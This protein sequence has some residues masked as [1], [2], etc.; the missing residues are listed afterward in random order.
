MK[1]KVKALLTCLLMVFSVGCDRGNKDS[2]IGSNIGSGSFEIWAAPFT[3]K[4]LE[5][6]E[7]SEYEAVKSVAAINL[8]MAKDEKEYAQIV[9]SSNDEVTYSV[10]LSDLTLEGDSSIK[11]PADKVSVYTAMYVGVGDRYPDAMLPLSAAIEANENVVKANCNQSLYFCF[12]VSGEMA[13]GVYTGTFKVMVGNKTEDVPVRVNVRNINVSAVVNSRACFLSNWHYYLGEYNSTQEMMNN[14]VKT[15]IDYRLCASNLMKDFRTSQEDFDYYAELVVEMYKYGCDE[16]KFGEGADRFSTYCI[17]T[18]LYNETDYHNRMVGFL[19]AIAKVSCREGVDLVSRGLVYDIDEPEGLD[20]VGGADAAKRVHGWYENG[21]EAA[22]ISLESKRSEWKTQYGV[23]DEFVDS[24]VESVENIH[25]IVTQG[26]MEKYE[27]S[28]ETWCPLFDSY[29]S[30][31]AVEK[32]KELNPDERWWY[33]CVIPNVPYPTYRITDT[34]LAPRLVGW[35]QAYYGVQGNLYW[36]VDVFAS[37]W[38]VNN[39]G[40]QY[41]YQDE[42][43]SEIANYA[44]IPGDGFLLRPGK[45]YGI[46]GPIPTIRIAS[47]CDGLEEYE[48]LEG[49][50]TLYAEVSATTGVECSAE[51]TILDMI[52]SM[53]NGMQL[54]ATPKD[55]NIARGQLL[56]LCE[57]SESGVAFVNIQDNGKGKMEYDVFV[58]SGVELKATNVTQVSVTNVTGGKVYKYS[59]DMTSGSA[60]ETKFTATTENGNVYSITK[61]IPYKVM[62]YGATANKDALSG[63]ITTAMVET[64]NGEE[65]LKLSLTEIGELETTRSQ[66]ISFVP[67]YLK[68][69]NGNLSKVTFNFEFLPENVNEEL[70]FKVYIKYKGKITLTEAVGGTLRYGSNEFTWAG[71][72]NMDWT[73]LEIERIDFRFDDAAV[74]TKIE[75]RS[76]IYFKGVTLYEARG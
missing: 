42:Y 30:P 1:R 7:S 60:W 62:S 55:F 56:D 71:L 65:V 50:K 33:G 6:K 54:S 39:Q 61:N 18:N 10:E 19:T 36:G 20:P 11:L 5:T 13:S 38:N 8:D 31:A 73:N 63:H 49:L 74:G 4:V 47:I 53:C 24:L 29:D 66:K 17:P 21:K 32:Y 9:I 26:Y 64:L 57:F 59:F 52:S 75:A 34:P 68:S 3:Q 48:L 15:L 51:A 67:S 37:Y 46:D 12:D 28:V 35:L 69:I 43:Y 44:N 27:G 14:Y 16:E 22:V 72:N 41:R 70:I 40:Y 76:D 23:T 2:N 45:K 25:H 58:P